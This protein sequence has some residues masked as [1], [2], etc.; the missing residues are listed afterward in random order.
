MLTPIEPPQSPGTP[1]RG[2]WPFAVYGSSH[3][4]STSEGRRRE[5][6]T[7]ADS[8]R[9]PLRRDGQL[10]R[11]G[12]RPS[13]ARPREPAPGRPVDGQLRAPRR[14]RARARPAR[15][16][17]FRRHDQRPPGPVRV[18]PGCATRRRNAGNQPGHHHR[19]RQRRRLR[20]P[21]HAG[22]LPWRAGLSSSTTCRSCPR[23]A[24]SRNRRRRPRSRR[25]GER[26]RRGW[27]RPHRR[28]PVPPAGHTSRPRPRP[29]IT[30]PGRRSRGRG[31]STCPCAGERRTTRTRP[32][33]RRSPGS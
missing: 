27:R 5:R 12:T 18:R 28:P 26:S 6:R 24:P 7:Y 19:G 25:G 1:W 15:R 9:E 3:R 16:H 23:T 14:Q 30:M 11:G 33:W 32:G 21:A 2:P 8:R 29:P 20:A 17:L 31:A 13:V 22:Q 4:G 10:V